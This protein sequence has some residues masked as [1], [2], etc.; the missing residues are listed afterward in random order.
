MDE[1]DEYP[2]DIGGQGPADQQ[3]E[4]R[5]MSYGDRAKIYRAC[6]PTIAGAS[7]IEAGH[8]A[9]DQRV[10]MVHCPHCGG[11]QTLEH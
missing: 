6:T 11:E 10:Y 1:V 3:L 4:A 2:K 7:A 9:G 5:A 8:A